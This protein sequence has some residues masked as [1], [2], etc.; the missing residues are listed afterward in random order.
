MSIKRFRWILPAIL[1]TAILA[2]S[3]LAPT[4]QA[5]TF[6]F[7][8]NNLSYLKVSCSPD[9]VKPGG[10]INVTV[11]AKLL[12]VTN[13]SNIAHIKIYTDT[14]AEPRKT[15]TEGDMVI[16]MDATV[17]TAQYSVSIPTNAINN[18]YIQMRIDYDGETF[19]G[20]NL[21][22]IQNPTYNDLMAIALI[23]QSQ[24]NKL[25]ENNNTINLFA[26]VATFIAIVFIASTAYIIAITLKANKKRKNFRQT[27]LPSTKTTD[28]T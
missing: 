4:A 24:N 17:G 26:Y 11:T 16:P 9:N 20:I 12:F 19:S 15:I 14:T 10:T 6:E 27:T 1:I 8:G 18:T 23:L 13:E 3:V 21:A 25:T 5:L 22:L 28:S 7:T 2:S